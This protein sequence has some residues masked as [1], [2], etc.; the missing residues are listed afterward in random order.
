MSPAR[1]S[2]TQRR[3]FEMLME[4]QHWPKQKMIVYQRQRLMYLLRHARDTVPFYRDRLARLFKGDDVDWDRWQ[5]LP[6]VT[7]ED[8]VD[9]RAEMQAVDLDPAHGPTAEFS[10]SGS[11]G[12]PVTTTHNMAAVLAANATLF[13]MHTWHQFDWSKNVLRLE[14]EVPSTGAYPEGEPG[15]IWGPAWDDEATGKEYRLNRLATPDQLFEFIERRKIS[16]FRGGGTD[17]R[18]LAYE[19]LRLGVGVH[20]EAA[21]AR[22]VVITE[23]GEEL[24]FKAFG[25]PTIPFYSSKEGHKMAHRCSENRNYHVAS[26]A[27]LLE[28]LRPDGSECAPGETG[29][30]VVTPLFSYAQPLIRYE[31]GDL[32]LV[33]EPCSCGRT[34]PVLANILG[35]VKHVFHRLDGRTV[36]PIIPAAPLMALD[37]QNYQI[38]Q[39]DLRTIEV[40]YVPRDSA[41]QGN[42][43]PLA[44]AIRSEMGPEVSVHFRRLK[45]F[46]VPPGRKHLEYVSEMQTRH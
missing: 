41:T 12:A 8:L 38:A 26:E 3:F 23:Y 17:L 35:R 4:S 11:T 10:T 20:L 1:Y 39:V 42:E 5:D 32:A 19:A 16:Y 33:G 13:R 7:R 9:R 46:E 43:A 24:V 44:A 21:M 6:T 30:V 14:G 29:R 45:A 22:S 37:A 27:V 34:L 25:A 31:Q 18:M 36:V 40:R 15:Q 28:I 2:Q